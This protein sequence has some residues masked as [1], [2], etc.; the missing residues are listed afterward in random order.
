M[1]LR[2]QVRQL[3]KK[4]STSRLV[5]KVSLLF[6]DESDEDDEPLSPLSPLSFDHTLPIYH[7]PFPLPH[8]FPSPYLRFNQFFLSTAKKPNEEDIGN[9]DVQ[10]K[11]ID[12]YLERIELAIDITDRVEDGIDILHDDDISVQLDDGLEHGILLEHF[13]QRLRT[14]LELCLPSNPYNRLTPLESDN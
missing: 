5:E 3:V 10:L 6:K 8:P 13:V 2:L 9:L 14:P 11:R 4:V 7:R 12:L 1:S